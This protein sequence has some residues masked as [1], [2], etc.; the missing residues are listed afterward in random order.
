[1]V[2]PKGWSAES[3]QQF[4]ELFNMVKKDH[5]ANKTCMNT[6]LVEIKKKRQ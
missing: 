4:N 5:K 1:M 6:W 3:I 2:I